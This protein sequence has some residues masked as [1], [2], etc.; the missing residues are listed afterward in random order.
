M[1]TQSTRRRCAASATPAPTDATAGPRR[2]R[3]RARRREQ[4]VRRR[5]AAPGAALR[6]GPLCPGPRLRSEREPGC[7][8]ALTARTNASARRGEILFPLP[9][10]GSTAAAARPATCARRS[11]ATAGAPADVRGIRRRRTPS[12]TA[13]NATLLGVAE[14]APYFH[15]GRFATLAEVVAWFDRAFSLGLSPTRADLT[16]YLQAV[17]AVD[18]REDDRRARARRMTETF[19]YLGL[20]VDGEAR[21]DRGIWNAAIDAALARSPAIRRT[22]AVKAA[23]TDARRGCARSPRVNAGAPLATCARGDR[24]APASDPSGGGL[25]GR[26]TGAGRLRR[27]L[28]CRVAVAAALRGALV[29][30]AVGR[31]HHS[32]SVYRAQ[33]RARRLH[34]HAEAGRQSLAAPVSPS[35]RCYTRSV[36]CCGAMD[37]WIARSSSIERLGL[38]P[39]PERGH[40]V[41]TLSRALA[42]ARAPHGG[43]RAACTAIY[44]LVTRAQ[45][46]TYLHRLKSDELFHLYEGGPLDVL[47]LGA[48]GGGERAAAPRARHRGGGAPADRHHRRHLVRRRAAPEASHCLFGCTVTPGFDFADSE[49]PRGPS[50]PRVIPRTRRASAA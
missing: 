20:L 19:V 9:R 12:T 21:D 14:S 8:R 3:V 29:R 17:G 27:T 31:Q 44:F 39:A 49:R 1:R 10:A 40:Y 2:C 48:A 43:A 26:A 38:I 42:V 11:F 5:A 46:T 4:R 6:A 25:V 35:R 47:L 13:S 16:S 18:R 24:A 28:W 7:A 15:D 45:P 37:P 50:W 23:I 34:E 41:E 36:V 33:R 22:E 32:L 30:E